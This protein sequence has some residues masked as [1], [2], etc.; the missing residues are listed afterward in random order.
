[1]PVPDGR[2]NNFHVK[3]L[4]DRFRANDRAHAVANCDAASR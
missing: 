2:G 3:D 1:V 4:V